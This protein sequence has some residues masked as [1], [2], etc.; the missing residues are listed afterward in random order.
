MTVQESK[1]LITIDSRNAERNTRAVANELENLTVKGDKADAQLTE[2]S[3]SIKS[4]V[5]YMGGLLT[6][7]K[8]IAMADGY[9]QMA[10]RI[11]EK[12]E[13]VLADRGH[14]FCLKVGTGQPFLKTASISK[15]LN[16]PMMLW[17]SKLWSM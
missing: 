8:A 12:Q 7:N 11:Y 16:K 2:M 6:I 4:L 5:G 17:R 1:L 3:S 9:T 14:F 10:A 15:L 13:C